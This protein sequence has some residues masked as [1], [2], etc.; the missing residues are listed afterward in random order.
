MRIGYKM[1]QAVAF[2]RRN[3][4]C[5]ILPVAEYVGPH[6]SRKRGYEIVHR[7]I[8]S[9]LIQFTYSKGRYSLTATE[10]PHA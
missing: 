9:G 3:P 2:V 1:A 8:D 10:P 4:G 7:A 5:A 6:R